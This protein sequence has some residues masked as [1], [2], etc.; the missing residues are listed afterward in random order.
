MAARY[1]FICCTPST[2]PIRRRAFPCP[3][4]PAKGRARRTGGGGHRPVV[5]LEVVAGLTPQPSTVVPI[6]GTAGI[7]EILEDL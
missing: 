1:M 7:F 5:G 2:G 4:L 6:A 3:V